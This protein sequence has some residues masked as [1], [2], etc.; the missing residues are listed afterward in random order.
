[1]WA[2]RRPLYRRAILHR[3]ERCLA[4]VTCKQHVG[5]RAGERLFLSQYT[6]LLTTHGRWN[7]CSCPNTRLCIVSSRHATPIVQN[8]RRHA[9]VRAACAGITGGPCAC[10][11][12]VERARARVRE[13]ERA[14][15]RESEK[16]AHACMHTRIQ[17]YIR[18]AARAQVCPWLHVCLMGQAAVRV[19][20]R[21]SA[22]GRRGLLC[23]GIHPF[24][25]T[26]QGG[27]PC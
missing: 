7:G 20:V 18:E 24:H 5:A 15:G 25:Q 26:Q 22:Q 13:R 3:A 23:V 19:R 27:R 1:M 11:S 16:D 4:C 17:T 21:T 10:V 14:R 9:C 2:G 8:S 12:I 6:I